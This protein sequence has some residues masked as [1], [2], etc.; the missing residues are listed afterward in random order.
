MSTTEDWR[1]LVAA[2][3]RD[4]FVAAYTHPFLLALSGLDAPPPPA[5]T[6]RMEG[7]PELMNA[8]MAERRRLK[9]ESGA[10]VG[11]VVLPVRKVQSTFPSM[12]TVGRAR[13][14][15]VV[16]PD[17]LVSKFHAFFRHLDDGEW[18]LADAG[19]ANGTKIGDVELAPKG[20]PERVRSGDKIVFGG[21]S[22][23]R[24]VDAAGLWAALHE[25]TR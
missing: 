17:A 18:G 3:G 12:I 9:T 24:F 14:N 20:Q 4:A 25:P 11:P 13:N 15:D 23:F 8:I 7:G 1:A 2:R 19:S 16:V 5:R 6:I 22:A 21:V 10:K